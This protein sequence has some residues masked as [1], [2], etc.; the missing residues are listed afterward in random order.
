MSTHLVND[1]LKYILI[2]EKGVKADE[3]A[4][5]FITI[6]RDAGCNAQNIADRL[7]EIL[8]GK[9][10]EDWVVLDK[11]I[12]QQAA[13]ELKLQES[14]ITKLI[15]EERSLV[16]DILL[17]FSDNYYNLSDSK[18]KKTIIDLITSHANKGHIIFIGRAAEMITQHYPNGINVHLTAPKSWRIDQLAKDHDVSV[19]KAEEILNEIDNNRNKYRDL[20]TTKETE[21]PT[22]DISINM[23]Q[24]NENQIL[25]MILEQYRALS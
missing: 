3:K 19:D 15:T 17:S 5:P 11:E 7:A 22:Y 12:L 9:T 4:L 18:L 24:I 8:N 10:E 1:Y 14:E 16:K 6:S 13:Q 23:A 2:K 25:N 21:E 20:F